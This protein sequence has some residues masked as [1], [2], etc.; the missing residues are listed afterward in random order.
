MY[1]ASK[2]SNW[3]QLKQVSRTQELELIEQTKF[4][5]LLVSDVEASMSGNLCKPIICAK[6]SDFD[7]C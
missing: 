6:C 7:R 5:L 1:N 2:N 4:C 3:D